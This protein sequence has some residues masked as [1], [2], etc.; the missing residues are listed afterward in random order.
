MQNDSAS[1]I[2]YSIYVCIHIILFFR[3]VMMC[4]KL[5]ILKYLNFYFTNDLL[6]APR[7]QRFSSLHNYSIFRRGLLCAPRVQSFW[8][9]CHRGH[10]LQGRIFF[11]LGFK[12]NTN[13][14]CRN[15]WNSRYTHVAHIPPAPA[16]VRHYLLILKGEVQ[17]R[18]RDDF[19]TSFFI[20]L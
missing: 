15:C 8:R 17:S 18:Q 20:V 11:V 16:Q 9:E 2:L 6:C 1:F 10:Q 3:R 5:F 14:F 7:V 12:A 19:S 4:S 13:F